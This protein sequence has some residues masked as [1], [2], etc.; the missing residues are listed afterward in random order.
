MS[1]Y[2]Y[3]LIIA[4]GGFP[5]ML[6]AY[7]WGHLRGQQAEAEKREK[8]EIERHNRRVTGGSEGH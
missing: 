8:E 6:A 1:G 5:F 4:V 3:L 7:A 2:E